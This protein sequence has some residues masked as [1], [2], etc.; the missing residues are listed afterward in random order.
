MQLALLLPVA[1]GEDER[2][3]L[4]ASS[5]STLYFFS[6]EQGQ[7]FQFQGNSVVQRGKMQVL[8]VLQINR[9]A[10]CDLQQLSFTC[11]K[12]YLL[13]YHPLTRPCSDFP[14]P[15]NS[16]S[17]FQIR[18][19]FSTRNL[20]VYKWYFWPVKLKSGGFQSW[21]E[22]AKALLVQCVPGATAELAVQTELQTSEGWMVLSGLFQVSHCL[23]FPSTG[24][25]YLPAILNLN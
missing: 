15:S 24:I 12:S 16:F 10:G 4:P 9:E 21:L 20:I 17:Y 18:W 5:S 23:I 3:L 8:N 11:L 6:L 2:N 19:Y 25:M 13:Y 22:I 1:P 7:S 14:L